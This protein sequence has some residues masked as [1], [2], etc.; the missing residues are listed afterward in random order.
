VHAVN[1]SEQFLAEVGSISVVRNSKTTEEPQVSVASIDSLGR[2][3]EWEE[4]PEFAMV[5]VDSLQEAIQLF[6]QYSPQFIVSIISDS[7]DEKTAVWNRANAPFVGDGMT[8]WVDGQ[9]AL[10]RPELG[11]SN[12]ENGRLFARSGILSGDSAFTVRLRVSQSNTDLHR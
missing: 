7:P 11:L 2:E 1:G 10:L 12:W 9:F 6:N 5:V 3:F 4:N 8:R